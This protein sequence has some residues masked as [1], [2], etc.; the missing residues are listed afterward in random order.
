MNLITNLDEPQKIEVYSMVPKKE[1]IDYKRDQMSRIPYEET[2]MEAFTDTSN[3]LEED[4][5]EVSFREISY[6]SSGWFGDS[7]CHSLRKPLVETEEYDILYKELVDKYL[8]GQ[9]CNSKAKRITYNTMKEIK[10]QKGKVCHI[11]ITGKYEPVSYRIGCHLMSNILG[12]TKELYILQLLE[13]GS[14]KYLKDKDI[15]EQLRLF[16]VTKIIGIDT[17]NFDDLI[18]YGIISSESIPSEFITASNEVLARVRNI[19]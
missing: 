4:G 13:N 18:K 9:L 5:I 12:L 2:V 1:L 7:S 8:T 15:E 11:L 6:W 3:I 14:F 19:K 16:D 10:E 17:S